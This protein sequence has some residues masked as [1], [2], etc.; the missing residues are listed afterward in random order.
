MPQGGQ[1][2]LAYDQVQTVGQD[3]VDARNDQDVKQVFH[4]LQPLLLGFYA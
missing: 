2:D 1:T 4:A 3:N